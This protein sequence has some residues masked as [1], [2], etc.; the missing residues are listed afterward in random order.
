MFDGNR[1]L[2]AGLVAAVCVLIFVVGAIF[3]RRKIL[4]SATPVLLILGP[5]GLPV[6][7]LT[8]VVGAPSSIW[9]WVFWLLGTAVTIVAV[10]VGVGWLVMRRYDKQQKLT[11]PQSK[12]CRN[13][14]GGEGA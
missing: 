11:G 12:K 6:A 2:V 13:M 7:F 5:A 4:Q 8:L 14:G 3:A 1:H 9:S 10:L